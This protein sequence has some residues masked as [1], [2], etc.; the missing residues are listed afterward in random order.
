MALAEIKDIGE[1]Q[2]WPALHVGDARALADAVKAAWGSG[3]YGSL[4]LPDRN[5]LDAAT[6]ISEFDGGPLARILASTPSG[7]RGLAVWR[8]GQ[9]TCGDFIVA[10]ANRAAL[11]DPVHLP[12]AVDLK[13]ANK[14][15]RESPLGARVGALV[16][17][18]AASK[19]PVTKEDGRQVADQLK[20]ALTDWRTVASPVKAVQDVHLASSVTVLLICFWDCYYEEFHRMVLAIYLSLLRCGLG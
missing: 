14:A 18:L 2:K 17:V 15:G 4:S 12:R 6:A 9:A 5:A 8:H 7:Q 13:A 16:A 3:D 1:H 20:A 11:A 10:S 19:R